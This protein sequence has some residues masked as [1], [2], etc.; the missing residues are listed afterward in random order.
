MTQ[1][2]IGEAKQ[3]MIKSKSEKIIR[4]LELDLTG[5]DGNAH[6]LLEYAKS[7]GRQLGWDRRAIDLVVEMMMIGDYENLVNVFDHHFGDFVI[8]Y[9]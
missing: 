4:R 6:V 8:L 3:K 5:P 2:L 7:F 9:R 1:S